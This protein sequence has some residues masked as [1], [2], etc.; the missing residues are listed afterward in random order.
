MTAMSEVATW[1][2]VVG[3]IFAVMIVAGICKEVP[4]IAA[5]ASR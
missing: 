4:A 5:W 2:V 1:E 3:S